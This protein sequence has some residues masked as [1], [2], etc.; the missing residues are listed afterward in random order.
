MLVSKNHIYLYMILH[1]ERVPPHT[2]CEGSRLFYPSPTEGMNVPYIVTGETFN[3]NVRGREIGV[4][5]D[6]NFV[7]TVLTAEIP[8]EP[9]WIVV[10]SD[11]LSS[12]VTHPLWEK[13]SLGWSMAVRLRCTVC[14]PA[15]N[16]LL[17]ARRAASR[18]LRCIETDSECSYKLLLGFFTMSASFWLLL[19]A[20]LIR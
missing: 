11:H 2:E 20:G 18:C 6:D 3:R 13:A 14:C 10:I 7:A 5:E 16:V 9:R 17:S 19:R 12:P 15:Y 8:E 4:S 1:F